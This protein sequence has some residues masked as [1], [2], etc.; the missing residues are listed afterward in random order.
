[1]T[2]PLA[3]VGP[4]QVE[5]RIP[6]LDIARGI[7]LCGILL[8]NITVFGLPKSYSDPTIY[9]GATGPD[10][11]A[12]ITTTMLF[13]G[14]QRGLFSLLFGAGMVIMTASLDRSTRPHAQDFFFRRNLWLVFFGIVHSFLLLWTGE[15]LY[16]YGATALFVY[17]FR[18]ANPRT[19]IYLAVGGLVFNAAWNGLDT[20]NTL[21][22]HSA[23]VV[24]DSI[25]TQGDSLTAEQTKAVEAWQGVLKE[26]KPDSA[27]IEEEIA[28]YQGSYVGIVA[29]Q[30]ARNTRYQSWWFY[31]F[32]FDIWSMMVIGIALFRLGLFSAST[33]TRTYLLIAG[34]G[35][36]VGLTTN[37]VELQMVLKDNFSVLSFSRAGITYD[38]GRLAMTTGHLGL[39]LL[40]CRAS[41]G[42]WLRNA[43]AALGRMAFT[44]YIMTS[45]ICA[46][47]F[48]GFGFGLY[49]ELRRHQLYYVVG[50]IWLFQLILSPWWLS[51]YRFGPLEY[52]WRWLTYGEKPPMRGAATAIE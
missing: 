37:Y 27:A 4:T 47:V 35:Y 11:W 51:R 18:N 8:M 20:Y 9:G 21:K 14:T 30:A 33:P 15:I 24:A 1:M 6:S 42:Q 39:I 41:W 5:S 3:D 36:A 22:K 49:G 38:L 48:Y 52:L 13:E 45:I 10:L 16:Y 43:L 32:F 23:F 50:A 7:A 46:I 2:V 19:L 17:G 25:K 12:W 34:V 44:N 26:A 29:G 40:F 28:L 31:R